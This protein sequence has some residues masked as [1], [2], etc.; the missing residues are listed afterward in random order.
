MICVVVQ[1]ATAGAEIHVVKRGGEVTYH[2]PG[3]C[4]IYPIMDVRKTG[5][6]AFVNALENSII[7]TLGAWGI[8]SRSA[9]GKTAGV[10]LL[11]SL[12]REPHPLRMCAC[13][14]VVQLGVKLC[15][16]C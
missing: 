13:C 9:G 8:A 12:L 11:Q 16:V 15:S 14:S 1:L 7:A 6:R 5:A 2:G 10:C 3:Q 4:I